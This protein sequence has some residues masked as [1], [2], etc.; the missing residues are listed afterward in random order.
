MRREFSH[1]RWVVCLLGTCLVFGCDDDKGQCG[2]GI[3]DKG[4]ACDDGNTVSGDGCS[5]DCS[6]VES[7]FDCPIPGEPCVWIGKGRCGDGILNVGE[8]CDDGNTVSGDGCSADCKVVEEGYVCPVPGRPCVESGVPNVPP[9]CRVKDS[10]LSLMQCSAGEALTW[11]QC[12][13]SES[14]CQLDPNCEGKCLR[15]SYTAGTCGREEC[16]GHPGCFSSEHCRGP[17]HCTLE[18]AAM[19]PGEDWDND[20]IPNG[21]EIAAGWDPCNA[22][23][24]GDGVPDGMEDLNRDGK[25]ETILGE[26]DPNDP[27]SVPDVAGGEAAARALVCDYV[28]MKG[29]DT[30]FNRMRVANFDGLNYTLHGGQVATFDDSATGVHGFFVRGHAYEGKILFATAF[31]ANN[32]VIHS[33]IEASNFTASVPLGAWLENAVYHKELQV[34]PDHRVQRLKYT[35]E[36]KA[37]KSIEEFRDALV[38]PLYSGVK[39]ATSRTLCSGGVDGAQASVYLSR[40]IHTSGSEAYVIYGMAVAC[41]DNLQA[42]VAANNRMDDVISGTMVASSDYVAF[43]RFVCQSM[44]FGDATG[45]VDFIWVVDNSGSMADELENVARTAGLFVDRLVESGIDYR[46]AVTTTDAF[47]VEEWPAAVGGATGR[48]PADYFNPMALRHRV[49]PWGFLSTNPSGLKT[50]FPAMVSQWGACTRFGTSGKNICGWGREDGFRSGVVALQRL[51]DVFD[52][53]LAYCANTTATVNQIRGLC[54]PETGS[55]PSDPRC[56][57]M[58]LQGYGC[59]YNHMSPACAGMSRCFLRDQ[60]LKYIIWVSDEESRQFKEPVDMGNNGYFSINEY[61]G[62]PEANAP[63]ICICKTGYQLNVEETVVGGSVKYAYS[64]YRGEFNAT[65]NPATGACSIA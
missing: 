7:E 34:V 17:E 27:S 29:I 64:M 18:C 4:E 49:S 11:C 28:K 24:D 10:C 1:W 12:V 60:A 62:L 23:T 56:S 41:D 32:D 31:P 45:M 44:R 48:S 36:L 15:C 20:G 43:R 14:K 54:D 42:S 40:S 35:V 19:Y 22:D 61:N 33:F 25:I 9:E 58:T 13:S 5:A 26:T 16:L 21:I 59:F 50:E 2:D 47:V 46:V 65:Y 57:D 37:G 53:K 52:T 51:T 3:L 55:N 8:A 30:P 6:Q 38:W 63:R 39:A